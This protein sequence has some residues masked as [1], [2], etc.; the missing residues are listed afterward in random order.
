MREALMRNPAAH[1]D[2]AGLP[3]AVVDLGVAKLYPV[4]QLARFVLRARGESLQRAASAWGLALPDALRVNSHKDRHLLWQGPDEFLLLALLAEVEDITQ[5]LAR[6]MA[7][8]P[9]SLV[10]VS[11]RN[12]AFLLTGEGAQQLLATGCMLDLDKTAFPVGMTTRT[13][14][15][16]A[17]VT[18]WRRD[19]HTFHIELWRSFAPYVISLLQQSAA[20]A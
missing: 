10:D 18:V 15:A 6:T 17:D 9:Y 20:A 13:L 1:S 2:D 8:A 14:F 5:S 11:Q 4:P 3:L 12:Q 16:K 19:T 7:D